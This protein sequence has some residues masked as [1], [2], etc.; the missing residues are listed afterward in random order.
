MTNAVEK[1]TFWISQGK[2]TTVYRWGGQMYKLYIDAKFSQDLTYQKSLKSV[3]FWESNLK[4]KRWT[5]WDIACISAPRRK[6]SLGVCRKCLCQLT[7]LSGS[8]AANSPPTGQRQKSPLGKYT[9]GIVFGGVRLCVYLCVPENYWSEMW[10][11]LLRI[12]RSD[13]MSVTFDLEF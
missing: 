8:P 3:N 7:D 4:I 5:F 10:C 2:V 6:T 12:S 9:R 11:N 13:Y 1:I